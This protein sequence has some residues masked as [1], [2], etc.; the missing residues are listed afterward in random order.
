MIDTFT[1]AQYQEA[2]NYIRSKTKHQPKIALVLG[3]GFGELA[4][5]VQNADV[6]SSKDIPHWPASTVEGHSGQL[7][8]GDLEGKPVLVQQGRAHYYEG[9]S[10][11]QVTLPV[12]VMRELGITHVFFTNAAGG[13]NASFRAGDLMVLTDH[14]NF[15]GLGGVS[16]LR[17]PN[18]PSLGVRFLD[19]LNAYDKDLR[20]VA[21]QAAQEANINLQEGVYIALAGPTFESPAELRFLKMIGG[22]AV[23]MST[24]SEV[25]VARHGG[26]K[27]LAIS[28]ISNIVNLS[29]DISKPTTH[30]EVL[31]TGKILTPKLMTVLRGVLKKLEI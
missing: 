18:D 26:M 15:V 10:M 1:R 25:V 29:G 12:R 23:G 6:I 20:Q 28:G 27:V 30:V 17:G 4:N 5:A 9:H 2:A 7:V 21:K 13:I 8:I 24:A 22:D 3:S 16:P 19:M 31:E 14:I 11:Q